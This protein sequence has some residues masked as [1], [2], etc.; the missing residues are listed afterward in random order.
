LCLAIANISH[1]RLHSHIFPFLNCVGQI[2]AFQWS[3]SNISHSNSSNVPDQPHGGLRQSNSE[4]QLACFVL[5]F[6]ST[7]HFLCKAKIWE[8]RPSSEDTRS[9]R[10]KQYFKTDVVP[11]NGEER[12]AAVGTSTT[13]MPQKERNLLEF[14]SSSSS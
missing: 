2:A 14:P 12:A 9:R 10:E 11:T 13:A 7:L 1:H 5:L 3:A 6:V 8:M 4:L